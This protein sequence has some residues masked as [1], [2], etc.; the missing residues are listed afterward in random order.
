MITKTFDEMTGN[1]QISTS[2][3]VLQKSG[4][5]LLTP[6]YVRLS[7]AYVIGEDSSSA[8]L[9]VTS[10]QM[11]WMFLSD[12]NVLALV[13]GKRSQFEG[14]IRDSDTEI[15]S[16]DVVCIEEMHALVSLEFFQELANSTSA[17]FRLAGIDY[18]LPAELRADLAALLEEI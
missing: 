1:G 13:D 9:L 2:I 14:Y 18:E 7:F 16:N 4:G 11:D 17:R 15:I 5:F 10:Q 8:W 3:A 6:T 12:T